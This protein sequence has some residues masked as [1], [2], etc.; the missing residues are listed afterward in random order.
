MFDKLKE[1][2]SGAVAGKSEEIIHEFNDTIRTIKALGLAVNNVSV[3]MGIPPEI[4]ATITGSIDA[5]D[6]EEIGKLIER[7]KEKKIVTLLLEAL[8]TASNFKDQ[9]GELE[10]CGVKMDVKLGLSPNIEIGLLT[11]GDS[12][13]KSN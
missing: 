8:T 13:S 10:F 1:V 5:L 7:N 6:R 4:G 12:A 9:L 11:K 2:A 3:K